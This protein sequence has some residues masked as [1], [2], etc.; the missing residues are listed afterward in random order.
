MVGSPK[1]FCA[2]SISAMYAWW[3]IALQLA[4]PCPDTAGALPTCLADS[5]F[6][7]EVQRQVLCSADAPCHEVLDGA[8]GGF[9]ISDRH[10]QLSQN[11][12]LRAHM[13]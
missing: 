9:E 7:G 11:V 10:V 1:Y 5:T 12:H 3:Y 8:G 13:T 2:E 6:D 4:T